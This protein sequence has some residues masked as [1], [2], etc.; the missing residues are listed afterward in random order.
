MP[1]GHHPSALTVSTATA[2]HCLSRTLYLSPPQSATSPPPLRHQP[3][4][5]DLLQ[6]PGIEASRPP[7]TACQP[8]QPLTVS[9]A[10]SP[11]PPVSHRRRGHE[12][13]SISL[14]TVA[15]SQSVEARRAL[16]LERI[17]EASSY[18]LRMAARPWE[19]RL[20]EQATSNSSKPCTAKVRKN[21]VTKRI[22]T[23]PPEA[24]PKF[25]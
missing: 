19:T 15:S 4:T 18:S 21:N 16:R 17:G 7:S 6:P 25:L 22:S 10:L 8:P 2:P 14:F 13:C 23:K 1:T 20:L 11:P 5:V 9:L 3:R 12:N 24:V